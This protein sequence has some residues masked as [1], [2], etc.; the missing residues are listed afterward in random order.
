MSDQFL[1]LFLPGHGPRLAKLREEVGRINVA[2]KNYR[3]VRSILLVGERG[4]GKSQLAEVIAAHLYWLRNYPDGSREEEWRQWPLKKLGLFAQMRR[5]TLTALPDEL[6]ESALFGHKK[7][8]YTGA[9]V[10]RDGAFKSAGDVDLLLDEVGD[11]SPDIQGKLLEVL[12][13][14]LFRPLG[15]KW[16]DKAIDS[17][18][19]VLAATNRNLA[20]DVAAMRFRADLLDRLSTFVIALPPLRENRDQIPVM[21]TRMLAHWAGRFGL[22]EAPDIGMPDQDFVLRQYEWPGNIR[23]LEHALMA[24]FVGG[25]TQSLKE[26]VLENAQRLRQGAMDTSDTDSAMRGSIRKHLLL[27]NQGGAPRFPSFGVFSGK[28]GDMGVEVLDELNRNGS[29]DIGSLFLCSAASV[30]SQ[31]SG[32]R[33]RRGTERRPRRSG[34][35]DSHKREQ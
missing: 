17:Q 31:L 24:W 34:K 9:Y 22:A 27:V 1:E 10:D 32:W 11:A 33:A 20:A 7:G 2:H 30:Q 6:A 35:R 14:G 3:V 16:E 28:Y 23:E 21:L 18:V 4:T 19:R 5:Q 13:T 8:A 29:M 15:A 25:R 12:E 26:L